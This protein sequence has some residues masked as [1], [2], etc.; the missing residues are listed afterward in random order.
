MKSITE[1]KCIHGKRLHWWCA[2]CAAPKQVIENSKPY[3]N[4]SPKLTEAY[5]LFCRALDKA[6]KDVGEA[7]KELTRP[8]N[9]DDIRERDIEGF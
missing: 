9:Q 8:L 3:G 7:L 4:I 5:A 2:E 1:L 6:K